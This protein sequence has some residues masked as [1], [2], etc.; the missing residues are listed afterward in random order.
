VLSVGACQDGYPIEATLCDEFCLAAEGCGQDPAECVLACESDER[1]GP[2]CDAEKRAYLQCI[3]ALDKGPFGCRL[4]ESASCE[5]VLT[6]LWVCQGQIPPQ[7][8]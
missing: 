7:F 4:Y 8:R 2:G 6:S 5:P 3:G 1:F